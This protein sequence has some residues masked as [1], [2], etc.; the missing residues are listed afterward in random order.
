MRL[1]TD[2]P[3]FHTDSADPNSCVPILSAAVQAVPILI[4]TVHTVIKQSHI[5]INI[6]LFQDNYMLVYSM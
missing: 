2:L 3:Q 1:G 6:S 5:C 4:Q